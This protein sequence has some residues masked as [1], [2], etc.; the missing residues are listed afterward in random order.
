[1]TEHARA[2]R[3]RRAWGPG[4]A[5]VAALLALAYDNGEQFWIDTNPPQTDFLFALRRNSYDISLLRFF[6]NSALG[7]ID[8][9]IVEALSNAPESLPGLIQELDLVRQVA[10]VHALLAVANEKEHVSAVERERYYKQVKLP[11]D[12]ALRVAETWEEVEEAKDRW[13][14]LGISLKHEDVTAL[15]EFAERSIA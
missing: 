3:R 9:R 5:E 4:S 7:E 1:M 13:R 11:A 8:W 2:R 12:L 15:A 10:V 14:A 6:T